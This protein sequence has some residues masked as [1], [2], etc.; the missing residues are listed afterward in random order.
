[1]REGLDKTAT[2]LQYSSTVRKDSIK[3]FHFKLEARSA[4]PVYKQVKQAVKR[5]I[6]SGFLE[7][8]DQ[9][10]SIRE[11]ASR[12]NIHPNTI[13]KAYSQLELEGFIVSRPGS[14]YFVQVEEEETREE[15]RLLIR[16]AARDFV[17]KA[18]QMGFGREEMLLLIGELDRESRQ[19]VEKESLND[20]D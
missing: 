14:G 5:F 16:E 8:G 3:I 20:N 2:L 12:H 18:R 19:A 15:K 7:K 10:M 4:V 6:L 1:M 17:T 13:I 11:M 9:L